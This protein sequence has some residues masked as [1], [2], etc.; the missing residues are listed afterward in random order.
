MGLGAEL[1]HQVETYRLR[2]TPEAAGRQL[3][4]RSGVANGPDDQVVSRRA[5][6]ISR[7]Q[8]PG[9]PKEATPAPHTTHSGPPR[10]E[11]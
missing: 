3:R 2:T 5:E 4:T 1:G 8:V 9:H 7:Q 10:S 11:T 6:H